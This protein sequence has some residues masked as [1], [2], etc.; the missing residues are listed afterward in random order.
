MSYP[1]NSSYAA[2]QSPS[3]YQGGTGYE[4]YSS[5]QGAAQSA[6]APQA[7]RSASTH[8]RTDTGFS[9]NS[10][11][12]DAVGKSR[13][14]EAEKDA[15]QGAYGPS[16][17][18]GTGGAALYGSKGIFTQED[19]GAFG[20]RSVPVRIF[21]SIGCIIIWAILI[22]VSIVCLVV[23]FARPPN[24]AISGINP[25]SADD[26]SVQASGVT[27]NS[28]INF[29]VSNPNSISAT[30]T[31]L[32]AHAYNKD[33]NTDVDVGRGTIENKK[34]EANSNTTIHFPFQ[35]AYDLTK[36]RNSAIIK[37]VI[38]KCG[39]GGGGGNGQLEY[40]LKVDVR[41]SI[42]SVSI[43]FT[44]TR[45]LSFTCPASTI[46]SALQNLGLGDI[47]NSLGG[48]AWNLRRALPEEEE[49][50]ESR[51]VEE[52][53]GTREDIVRVTQMLGERAR[54]AFEERQ[55]RAQ[56]LTIEYQASRQ[57]LH[58]DAL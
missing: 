58:P 43:P 48:R 21:R 4:T 10:D 7:Y 22:I 57:A 45:P 37:D 8:K 12:G 41:L 13:S 1:F 20:A 50:S 51:S 31:K 54:D 38:S 42:L 34:I 18:S 44:I 39:L 24:V 47:I 5:S 30:I 52:R 36:D 3:P 46:S 6:A 27:F 23:I 15:G 35:L 33:V 2:Q 49:W 32:T 11:G 14:R 29:A 28:S 55:K 26:I 25:P 40:T 17:A 9:Y 53:L 56:P 16:Y 19:R